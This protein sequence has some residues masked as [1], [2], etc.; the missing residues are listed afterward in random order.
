MTSFTVNGQPV[1]YR[2]H[3]DTPL[4]F[5]LREASNLTGAKLGCGTGHCGACTVH[6]DGR[7]VRSCRV[8]I[9]KIEGTYVTTIEAFPTIGRIPCSRP[10]PPTMSRNADFVSRG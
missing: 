10:S 1:H 5:A 8:P 9:R 4:L 6:V 2:L 7:A 3:P